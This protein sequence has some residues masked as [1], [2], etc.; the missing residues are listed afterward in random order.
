MKLSSAINVYS[1]R[2][3]PSNSV[4][5]E[6]AQV[7]SSPRSEDIGKTG[8]INSVRTV[9]RVKNNGVMNV[10]KFRV[11]SKNFVGWYYPNEIILL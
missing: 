9:K 11:Q 8:I 3:K 2:L 1:A 10:K 5:N 7:I 4:L 6:Y